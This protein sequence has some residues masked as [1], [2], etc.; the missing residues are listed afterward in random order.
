MNGWYFAARVVLALGVAAAWLWLPVSLWAAFKF[1]EE[2]GWFAVFLAGLI[3]IGI[4]F[5]LLAGA[6]AT[7]GWA[8]G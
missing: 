8:F 5:G 6:I 1:D 4:A 7:A 3:V 2:S